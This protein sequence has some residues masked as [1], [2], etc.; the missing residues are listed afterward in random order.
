MQTERNSNILHVTK[1]PTQA[2]IAIKSYI[3]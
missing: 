1:P 2:P 3:S